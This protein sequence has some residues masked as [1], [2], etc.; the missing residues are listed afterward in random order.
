MIT[1][2]LTA[3]LVLSAIGVVAGILLAVA[4]HFFKVEENET[5]KAVRECLPGAN[6]GACGFAGCDAYAEAVADG[7]AEALSSDQTAP[8]ALLRPCGCCWAFIH[9]N[10]QA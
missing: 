4:S 1:S 7:K 8:A 3:L 5:V 9:A 10:L 2:I 6:F